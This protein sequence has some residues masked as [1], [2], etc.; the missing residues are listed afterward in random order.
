MGEHTTTFSSLKKG[1]IAQG[2]GTQNSGFTAMSTFYS[3]FTK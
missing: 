3:L 2:G 1:T